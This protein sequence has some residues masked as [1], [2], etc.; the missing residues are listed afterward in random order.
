MNTAYQ[1]S[2][3][4]ERFGR[5]VAARLSDS[6]DHLPH[7][8]SERLKAARMMALSKRNVV[9]VETAGRAIGFGSTAA[10]Q[11]GGERFGWWGR[12]A[13]SLPLFALVAGLAAIEVLQDDFWANEVASIDAELLT[14]ELP[15]S[16]YTDPGFTQY[17]R[18]TGRD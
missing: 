16:A 17:L 10:L 12:L 7:E 3:L 1:S 6:S 13:A 14:D 15:P 11:A 9:K 8:I 18:S 5:R 2:A 4:E